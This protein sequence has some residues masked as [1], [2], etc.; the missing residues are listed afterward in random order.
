[1]KQFYIFGRSLS[2]AFTDNEP[3]WSLH[4][5]HKFDFILISPITAIIIETLMRRRFHD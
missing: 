1:M 5:L 2:S 4:V 3:S